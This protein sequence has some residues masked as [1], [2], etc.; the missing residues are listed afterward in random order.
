MIG[1]PYHNVLSYCP[2]LALAFAN[3]ATLMEV[4]MH[5]RNAKEFTQCEC[6]EPGSPRRL[7]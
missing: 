1:K 7:C 3:L 5:K 4:T 6:F 2:P